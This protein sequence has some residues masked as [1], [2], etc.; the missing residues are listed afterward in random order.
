MYT[1]RIVVFNGTSDRQAR[2]GINLLLD[3]MR[4]VYP[5]DE[6][7]FAFTSKKIRQKI[8]DRTGE[9]VF[10]VEELFGQIEDEKYQKIIM[11]PVL[12]IAGVEY[13]SLLEQTEELREKLKNARTSHKCVI[14]VRTELLHQ[15]RILDVARLLET[16]ANKSEMNTGTQ[17]TDIAHLWVGHG[18]YSEYG[19]KN[20]YDLLEREFQNKMIRNHF[21]V[22]MN[23]LN[24]DCETA[25]AHEQVAKQPQNVCFTSG[26][27]DK[28]KEIE[29]Y[30][31]VVVH[32]LLFSLGYHGKKDIFGDNPESVIS[33]IRKKYGKLEIEEVFHGLLDYAVM[34]EYILCE[35]K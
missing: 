16:I 14:E 12:M 6:I 3:E 19:L 2:Q 7:M 22:T 17:D 13:Q 11:I 33:Y 32:P 4:Q 15:N 35:A 1:L 5:E 21:V 9:K 23:D 29:K 27:S 28:L 30:Q 18:D 8:F 31:T 20:G 34:R 26:N 10:S 25:C 24:A